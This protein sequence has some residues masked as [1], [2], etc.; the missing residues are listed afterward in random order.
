MDLNGIV[1]RLQGDVAS[2]PLHQ[3]SF[4][5]LAN[6]AMLQLS[7]FHGQKPRRFVTGDHLRDHLLHKLEPANFLAER[8]ALVC[9]FDTGIKA[10]ARKT[11]STGA[12]REPALVDAA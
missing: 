9:V 10:S 3:R 12:D 2:I 6:A 8:A 7:V 11:A 4:F 1:S 5:P